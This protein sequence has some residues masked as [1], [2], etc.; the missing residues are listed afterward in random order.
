MYMGS[1]HLP[2]L[3]A[4]CTDGFLL[5]IVQLVIGPLNVLLA[6]NTL[7]NGGRLW[8]LL[9]RVQPQ[10]MTC[11]T[12]TAISHKSPFKKRI[13]AYLGTYSRLLFILRLM[14]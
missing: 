9:V 1:E 14:Q 10:P 13:R 4:L 11:G 7:H 5:V 6:F 3:I 12:E 2:Y 8:S